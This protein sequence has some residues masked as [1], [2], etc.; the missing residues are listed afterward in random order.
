MGASKEDYIDALAEM[1]PVELT[2][3]LLVSAD[4][5]Y[6][7]S[8]VDWAEAVEEWSGGK[9]TF[10]IA[11]SGS[12]ADA[13]TMEDALNEGLVDVGQHQIQYKP[14]EFAVGNYFGGATFLYESS[15]VVGT[16]QM[17]GAMGQIWSEQDALVEENERNGL[18]PLIPATA[19]G[20]S[21][22]LCTEGNAVST[23]DDFDGRQV[24]ASATE[25]AALLK[26]LGAV[27]VDIPGSELFDAMQR[28]TVECADMGLTAAQVYGLLDV[29]KN[30]AFDSRV[31]ASANPSGFDM[32]LAAWEDLPLAAQQLL[33]DRLDVFVES[34]L[35][36]GVFAS[37]AKVIDVAIEKGITFND[38]DDEVVA[39]IDS[40]FDDQLSH[41]A[42][43]APEGVDGEAATTAVTD[44]FE[45]WYDLVT[46]ELGYD[47]EVGWQD[48]D[49]AW[50]EAN[51]I[52]L[53]PFVSEYVD[54]VLAPHRPGA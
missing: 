34:F 30:W 14:E 10:K 29:G 27:P 2:M 9:I 16:M 40:F 13:T 36:N 51:E 3:Q 12:I 18:K 37:N 8:A 28:G 48:F 39:T 5:D 46:N 50:L 49:S 41:L 38:Y 6:A 20:P 1:D 22:F 32:S 26:E 45:G 24:R 7:K 35:R 47:Q 53:E 23:L 54:V 4:A 19:T 25:R 21:A 33:W 42:D 52:D 17:V 43:S 15:P 44:A 31:S 11:Y